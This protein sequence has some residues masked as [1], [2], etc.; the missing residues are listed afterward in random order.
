MGVWDITQAGRQQISPHRGQLGLKFDC[1]S[2]K[3]LLPHSVR[4]ACLYPLNTLRCFAK[5]RIFIY[6]IIQKEYIMKERKKA[7]FALRTFINDLVG[8]S[9][10]VVAKSNKAFRIFAVQTALPQIELLKTMA[11]SVNP[12]WT[13][14]PQKS[15]AGYINAIYVGKAKSRVVTDED[16]DNMDIS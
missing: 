4:L 8:Q 15:D 9:N 1:G 2:S 5:Y 12:D 3:A 6:L 14:F 11:Q 13:A 16:V 7:L 10:F